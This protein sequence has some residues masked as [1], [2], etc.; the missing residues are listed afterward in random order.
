MKTLFETARQGD[1]LGLEIIDMHGHLGRI[2]FTVPSLSPGS[3]VDSMDRL[4]IRSIVCS[5]HRCMTRDTEWGNAQLVDM[6]HAHPGRILGYIIVYPDSRQYVKE[7]TEYWLQQG[8]IGLKFHDNNGFRYDDP[9]YEPAY[10]LADR[11]HLPMLFHTWGADHEFQILSDVAAS[12][13]NTSV[14]MAHAGSKQIEGYI[15]TAQQQPNIYLELAFSGSYIGLVDTLVSSVG[16]HKVIWGSDA[17]FINQA[18]QLGKVIGAN[19][20][21]TSKRRLISEN[22]LEILDRIQLPS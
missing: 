22:A 18:H 9:A 16:D 17:I 20:P 2:G 14:L 13:P 19:I 4:G 6:M 8:M 11:Y 12:H 7:N 10:A 1:P 15:D 5:H 3:L 21:D